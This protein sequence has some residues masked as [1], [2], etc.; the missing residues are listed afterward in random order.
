VIHHTG[1]AR[2]IPLVIVS[3]MRNGSLKNRNY[4]VVDSSGVQ[5]A[6]AEIAISRSDAE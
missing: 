6:I 5:A 2:N 4:L 1:A 3:H